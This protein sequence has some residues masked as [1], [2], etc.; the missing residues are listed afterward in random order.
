MGS[1]VQ[2]H[3]QMYIYFYLQ[4]ADFLLS[5]RFNVFED[6]SWIQQFRINLGWSYIT[7]LKIKAIYYKGADTNFTVLF[8]NM[9]TRCYHFSFTNFVKVPYLAN[10]KNLR[11]FWSWCLWLCR[12]DFLEQL[13][14]HPQQWLI[15]FRSK[16]LLTDHTCTAECFVPAV[17]YTWKLRFRK[18]NTCHQWLLQYCTHGQTWCSFKYLVI[19]LN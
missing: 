1:L 19:H 7:L 15:I 12:V 9:Q 5:F 8:K 6:V 3:W 2:L 11:R 18:G 10:N 16:Y 4:N 13:L 17:I 14:K